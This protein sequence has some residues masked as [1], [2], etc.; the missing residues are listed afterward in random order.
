MEE[1][2]KQ[3]TLLPRRL[4]LEY[5]EPLARD[6]AIQILFVISA[7]ILITL[8]FTLGLYPRE[9]SIPIPERF[10]PIYGAPSIP[11]SLILIVVIGLGF[12]AGA[13]M[14]SLFES[15]RRAARVARMAVALLTLGLPLT[16]YDSSQLFNNAWLL[17]LVIGVAIATGVLA[18]IFAFLTSP[19]AR[20]WASPLVTLTFML[21]ALYFLVYGYISHING[22]VELQGE[23]IYM[24]SFP[25]TVLVSYLSPLT[26]LAGIIF[27]WQALTEAQI[28]TRDVGRTIASFAGRFR[29]LLPVLFAIKAIAFA[30]GYGGT[31]L[32]QGAEPWTS[33]IQ[34]GP[35]SW[36]AATGLVIAAGWWLASPR[37][38]VES[39][40]TREAAVVI[41][42]G[43]L[44]PFILGFLLFILVT[45]LAGIGLDNIGLQLGQVS[46]FLAD[47]GYMWSIVFAGVLLPLGALFYRWH[48]FRYLAPIFLLTGVWALPRVISIIWPAIDLS[49]QY[50]TFDTVLTVVLFILAVMVWRGRRIGASVWSITLT[51]VVSSLIALTAAA[52]PLPVEYIF[53][54][55]I[56]LLLLPI[57]YELLFDA[58]ELN[59][60]ATTRAS[61]VVRQLSSQAILMLIITWSVILGILAPGQNTWETV[62]SVVFLPPL[63]GLIL[64]GTISK[65]DSAI[66]D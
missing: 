9:A 57:L 61:L 20:K 60:L 53:L 28:F 2:S 37:K 44:L 59:L 40:R 5:F 25:V 29:W 33:V 43:F 54:I 47:T 49:F 11:F 34:D 24:M 21:G 27:F 7:A 17:T 18:L 8:L 32:G 31:Q 23:V 1:K 35:L 64:A 56:A 22:P 19:R 41:T 10:N 65:H 48:R 13:L 30:I 63:V 46:T 15:N 45:V 3:R 39:V 16:L 14:F 66:Q 50:L 36:L 58:D 42:L 6:H 26:W 52:W 38:L 62:A 12:G 4:H 51:L 55:F